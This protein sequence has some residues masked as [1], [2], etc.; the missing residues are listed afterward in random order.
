MKRVLVQ[1]P[2]KWVELLDKLVGLQ[3]YPNRNEAI[4]VAIRELLNQHRQFE[5][6][7]Q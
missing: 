4:R 6:D 7:K 5:D 3:F 2:E 1:I